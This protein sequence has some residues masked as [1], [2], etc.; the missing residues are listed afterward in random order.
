MNNPD[1]ELVFP[2]RVI[3][4]LVNMHDKDWKDLV[5]FVHS[6]E[7]GSINQLGFVLMMVKLAGCSSC[8]SDFFV[9]C[10]AALN[11]RFKQYGGS[12]FPVW[13]YVIYLN[14]IELKWIIIYPSKNQTVHKEHLYWNIASE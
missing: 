8:N 4:L 6:N 2:L 13:N 12:I 11:V 1:T 5:D 9:P 7:V 10:G 14:K 3:P